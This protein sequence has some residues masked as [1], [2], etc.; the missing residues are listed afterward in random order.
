MYFYSDS[1]LMNYNVDF[2][3]LQEPALANALASKGV[4]NLHECQDYSVNKELRSY[5]VSLHIT[6]KTE[7]QSTV[8]NPETHATFGHVTQNKDK[9]NNT[10]LEVFEDTKGR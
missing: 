2:Y 8:G 10:T 4:L 7:G 9:E 1:V 5:R 6:Q 3:I